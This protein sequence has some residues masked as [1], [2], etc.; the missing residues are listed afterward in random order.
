MLITDKMICIAKLYDKSYIPYWEDFPSEMRE[1]I[2]GE[3]R[4]DTNAKFFRADS[5]RKLQVFL[6]TE[7]GFDEIYKLGGN[8]GLESL[9]NKIIRR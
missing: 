6:Y 2:V 4:T 3:G 9:V 1:F 8:Y 5:L 7:I